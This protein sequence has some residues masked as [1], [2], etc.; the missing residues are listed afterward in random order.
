MV[1]LPSKSQPGTKPNPDTYRNTYGYAAPS[2][3]DSDT[4]TVARIR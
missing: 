4:A 2:N 3:A 1:H